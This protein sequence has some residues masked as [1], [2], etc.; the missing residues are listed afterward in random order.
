MRM[1]KELA[2][3][4]YKFA[5]IR[6]VDCKIN[7]LFIF[8]SSLFTI[9]VI[10]F[11]LLYYRQRSQ[12]H[13]FM[14]SFLFSRAFFFNYLYDVEDHHGCVFNIIPF[15]QILLNDFYLFSS[16]DRTENTTIIVEELSFFYTS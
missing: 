12:N 16:N 14:L 9:S 10:T 8:F 7:L 5:F 6:F 4:W 15:P 1:M 2:R 3:C 13:I 11:F